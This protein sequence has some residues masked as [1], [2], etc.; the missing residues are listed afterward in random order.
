MVKNKKNRTTD[1]SSEQWFTEF[2]EANCQIILYL[3]S[4]QSKKSTEDEDIMQEVILRLIDHTDQL[5]E[6]SNSS[7][8]KLLSYLASTV[9]SVCVDC[10]RRSKNTHSITM[11]EKELLRQVTN[12]R[13]QTLYKE[14]DI[15]Q[16]LQ[17]LQRNLPKRDW[18]LLTGKYIDGLSHRELAK[19][20]GYSYGSVRMALSRAKKN[21]RKIL[22]DQEDEWI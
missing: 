22:E 7:S 20:T 19:Q 9:N 2:Y 17:M 15:Q 8:G 12:Q 16:T 14:Y 21:A 5:K 4:R 6:I 1:A 18:L 10:Y 11:P 13:I 3:I